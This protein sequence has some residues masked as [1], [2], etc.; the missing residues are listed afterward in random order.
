MSE[1]LNLIEKDVQFIKKTIP[2]DDI[3]MFATQ[4]FWFAELF[5]CE[6]YKYPDFE[7][8]VNSDKA[9][10][11]AVH[12]ICSFGIAMEDDKK[13]SLDMRLME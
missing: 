9:L 2:P 4:V 10:N 7:E 8:K 1:E 5:I 6:L 11:K 13:I 3:Y 12:N